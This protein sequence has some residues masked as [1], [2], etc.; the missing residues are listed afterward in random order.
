MRNPESRALRTLRLAFERAEAARLDALD[1]YHATVVYY[2]QR[3]S[4]RTRREAYLDVLDAYHEA[5]HTARIR[6]RTADVYEAAKKEEEEEWEE[7]GGDDFPAGTEFEL[8][9]TTE[10]GSPRGDRAFV[11]PRILHLKIRLVTERA[12]PAEV[13]RALLD[14]AVQDHRVPSGIQIYTIDWDK[15][16]GF[17]QSDDPLSTQ[18]R[19]FYGAITQG[20]TRFAP[21]AL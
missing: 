5:Q 11:D 1:F 18:L 16:D 7:E 20:S 19:H 2:N 3:R 10:G 14:R 9:A 4:D 6:A 8:T 21:V 15:G 17:E 12:M 13:A